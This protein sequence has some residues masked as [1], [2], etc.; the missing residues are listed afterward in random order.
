M[1]RG[2]VI[3]LATCSMVLVSGPAHTN[4]F[5]VSGPFGGADADDFERGIEALVVQGLVVLLALVVGGVA[6]V[7]FVTWLV[8]QARRSRE[9]AESEEAQAQLK[10]ELADVQGRLDKAEKTLEEYREAEQ[11]GATTARPRQ[12]Q[13][14]EVDVR[15]P[16]PDI[17]VPPKPTLPPLPPASA[18]PSQSPSQVAP[19]RREEP[20]Y[21]SMRLVLVAVALALTPALA[22]MWLA[23]PKQN[24]GPR[25]RAPAMRTSPVSV[26]TP[27]EPLRGFD[28]D[29]RVGLYMMDANGGNVL[30]S[31]PV[32]GDYG[33]LQFSPDGR[34]V[35]FNSERDG[36]PEIY[37]MDV[38]GT[39]L[40]RLT[41]HPADDLSAVW[42]PDGSRIA[43][44]SQRTGRLHIWVMD[45]DGTDKR[46]LTER[47]WNY[48]PFWSP[49]GARIGFTSHQDGDF[50][51][52]T[53]KADGTDPARLT[54]SPGR[55][56]GEHW[57]PDGKKILF[58]SNRDATKYEI[59]TM[60]A[61]GAEQ[62]RLTQHPARDAHAVWSPD[63]LAIAFVSARDGNQEIYVMREDGSGATNLTMSPADEDSPRWSPD[64]SKIAFTRVTPEAASES[65]GQTR[66]PEPTRDKGQLIVRAPVN[67]TVNTCS[68]QL[69]RAREGAQETLR[70]ANTPHNVEAGEYEI[71]SAQIRVTDA[72]GTLWRYSLRPQ[73]LPPGPQGE[74]AKAVLVEPDKETAIDLFADPRI[75]FEV[76]PESVRPGQT[77]RLSMTPAVGYGMRISDCR[78][79]ATGQPARGDLVVRRPDGS[80]LKR[81]QEG[82]G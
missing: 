75:V 79:E 69:R 80:T 8:C 54:H 24:A 13:T 47:S 21:A 27:R 39:N 62:R 77:V 43:W 7:V 35:V 9:A 49:D 73:S 38:D 28:L 67:V 82:F 53:M 18:T 66:T 74:V 10:R 46:Q 40:V 14:D 6:F 5:M 20:K 36:N 25:Y 4:G 71:V 33:R 16:P 30:R 19:P 29:P 44:Q 2:W 61:D 60:D 65:E 68:V 17:V 59:Y 26:P 42:S 12:Q 48:E 11:D 57:S 76:V 70:A 15:P 64:G 51:I 63:G 81:G 78:R 1:R 55:D 52:Y 31:A 72:D 32:T 34:K 58:V 50:E 23:R 45:A 41:N 37:A 22:I 56:F 3:L